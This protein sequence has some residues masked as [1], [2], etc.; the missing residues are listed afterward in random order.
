MYVCMYSFIHSS[1]HPIYL[2]IY[3]NLSISFILVNVINKTQKIFILLILNVFVLYISPTDLI[4][5]RMD[6]VKNS[7]KTILP[8]YRFG[9]KY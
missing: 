4:V 1:I 6:V 7:N 3:I 2:Y 5:L 8:K 9:F